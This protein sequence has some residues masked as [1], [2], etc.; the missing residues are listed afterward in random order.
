MLL[1]VPRRVVVFG[2]CWIASAFVG[3]NDSC[4]SSSSFTTTQLL[5]DPQSP[6]T[7]PPTATTKC[8]LGFRDGVE[9]LLSATPEEFR[10]AVRESDG[11]FLYR[12]S[13]EGEQEYADEERMVTCTSSNIADGPLFVLSDP[14]PDLLAPETYIDPEASA[15]FQRMEEVVLRK[16]GSNNDNDNNNVVEDYSGL[17]PSLAHVGTSSKRDAAEWGTP[18][19][20]WPVLLG[21]NDDKEKFSYC[22][23]K[24]RRV[25]HRR[26]TKGSDGADE[27]TDSNDMNASSWLSEDASLVVNRDLVTAL[28]QGKEVM[29]SSSS[30]LPTP[31]SSRKQRIRQRR[32]RNAFLIFPADRDD[33]LRAYLEARNYGLPD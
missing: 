9:L 17:A 23:P 30:P 26:L 4:S 20:V 25:I 7:M 1:V 8:I 3:D 13:E 31:T 22:W 21:D 10:T 5:L 19:S 27:S 6:R 15:F 14:E 24:D 11:S 16:T 2:C 33:E 29:F 12:G 32:R 28:R 18:V